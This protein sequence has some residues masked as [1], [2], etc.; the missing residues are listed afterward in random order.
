MHCKKVQLQWKKQMILSLKHFHSVSDRSTVL[1]NFVFKYFSPVG[2]TQ[3]NIGP[4]KVEWFTMWITTWLPTV[5]ETT[6][7]N[8]KKKHCF[9]LMNFRAQL[10]TAIIFE[11]IYF[12]YPHMLSTSFAMF[13]TQVSWIVLSRVFA[14]LWSWSRLVSPTSYFVPWR[15]KCLVSFTLH[16]LLPI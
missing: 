4:M 1:T 11:F 15:R 7:G 12:Q 6:S 3:K 2:R 13:S 14:I 5:I 16:Y 9:G 8:D 10:F